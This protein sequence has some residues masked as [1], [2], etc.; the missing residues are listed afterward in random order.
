MLLDTEPQPHWGLGL[1]VYTTLSSPIRRYLDIVIQRQ[2]LAALCHRPVPYSREALGELLTVLEPALRRAA[3][4]K[5]RRIRYWLLKYLSQR[6][7]Q[8]MPA[9]VLEQHPTR[10]RL[11][12][13]ELLLET[14]MPSP[15]GRQFHPGE[16]IMVR[17]D[18]AIPLD[19]VV[20]VS[21]A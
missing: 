14:E 17:I 12:L 13:P 9:L 4:L 6:L 19:D 3:I 5:T 8:K 7:G 16:T 20:K 11:L 2:L 1:P 18:R 10:Y 21:L 15:S